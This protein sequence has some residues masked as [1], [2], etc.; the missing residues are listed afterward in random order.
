MIF[1][2]DTSGQVCFTETRDYGTISRCVLFSDLPAFTQGYVEALL[3][4]I[5]ARIHPNSNA[6]EFGF[7][8][9]APE[10]LARIMADCEAADFT[11]V[12]AHDKANGASFYT[13]RQSG[14]YRA[15]P[16]TIPYLGDDGLIRLREEAPAPTAVDE[17][18]Q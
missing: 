11:P 13:G 1:Q 2:L 12:P 17:Y 7:R 6:I 9:L 14:C 5:D 10:T 4:E 16:P 3:R 18:G 8:H 15:F